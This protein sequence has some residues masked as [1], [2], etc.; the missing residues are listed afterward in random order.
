[1]TT[2]ETRKLEKRL[3][4]LERKDTTVPTQIQKETNMEQ[5][6]LILVPYASGP[7]KEFT[8]SENGDRLLKMHWEDTHPWGQWSADNPWKQWSAGQTNK[9]KSMKISMKTHEDQIEKLGD[10]IILRQDNKEYGFVESRINGLVFYAPAETIVALNGML[11]K[12]TSLVA[13]E[14]PEVLNVLG[15]EL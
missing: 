15:F 6:K 8:I 9:T 4:E 13:E 11:D 12:P 10:L 3:V 2:T 7:D 14:H 1:M 5:R